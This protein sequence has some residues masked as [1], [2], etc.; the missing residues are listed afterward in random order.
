MKKLKLLL[1]IIFIIILSIIFIQFVDFNFIVFATFEHLYMTDP[2]Y[3]PSPALERG[4]SLKRQLLSYY[5]VIENRELVNKTG[6]GGVHHYALY[7]NSHGFHMMTYDHEFWD[8][9][10][11]TNLS[12]M[13]IDCL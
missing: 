1:S 11:Q 4:W 7:I 2:G 13:I 10:L 5:S 6:C 12:S 3:I 9:W 8:S